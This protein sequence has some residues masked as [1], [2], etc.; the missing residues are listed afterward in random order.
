MGP[1]SMSGALTDSSALLCAESEG[2]GFP[3]AECC[4]RTGT[5][6][7]ERLSRHVV[8]CSAELES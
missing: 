1:E 3:E 2:K 8:L 5:S 7:A 4:G 6:G